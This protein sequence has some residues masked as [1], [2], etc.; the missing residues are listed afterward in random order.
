MSVA[1]SCGFLRVAIKESFHK[2][3]S[4]AKE[5]DP[6]QRW[7]NYLVLLDESP[8]AQLAVDR[9]LYMKKSRINY[10]L[11]RKINS[12]NRYEYLQY[13]SLTNWK[14]LPQSRKTEHTMSNCDACQVHH[15]AMQSV[16]PT[17]A[18][19]KP[20]KLVQDALAEN[21]DKGNTK[22]KPTQEAIKSKVKHINSKIDAPFQKVFKVSF[23]EAQT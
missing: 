8:R 23:A 7:Q 1:F 18:K 3:G 17:A 11:F 13:F 6:V 12:Q 14:A 2:P 9:T 20:Q 21:G 5:S 4:V 15:F 22:V 16:F 10:N 19:M